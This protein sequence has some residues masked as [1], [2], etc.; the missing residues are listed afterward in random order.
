MNSASN[1]PLF[2]IITPTFLAEQWLQLCIYSVEDQLVSIEHVIQDGSSHDQTIGI[3]RT[4]EFVSLESKPDRGMYHALNRALERSSGTYIG[5]L[6]ADEQYLP[7]VL[8]RVRE[9]FEQDR[10]I[11]VICGDMLLLNADFELVSYRRSCMPPN[12]SAGRLPLSIPTCALFWR[13]S[14]IGCSIKYREDLRSLSD[15]FFVEDLRRATEKWYFDRHPYAVF[16]T[17]DNNLSRSSATATDMHFLSQTENKF[18]RSS[19][20]LRIRHWTNRILA[21]GY[22]CRKVETAIYTPSSGRQRISIQHN[23]LTWRWPKTNLFF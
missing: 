5:H 11:D 10:S 21:G 1:P 15:S 6:N 2:S 17:H 3:A 19:F 20:G 23:R 8:D 14:I 12:K 18:N 9:I 13:K 7:G 22:V 4:S 16:V